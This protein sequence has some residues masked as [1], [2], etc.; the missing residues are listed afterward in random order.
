M[1]A[2]VGMGCRNTLCCNR[3]WELFELSL[4]GFHPSAS[5]LHVWWLGV[6]SVTVGSLFK[7][8]VLS[9]GFCDVYWLVLL[10]VL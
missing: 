9:S 5:L 2:K 8:L 4:S 10:C 3:N 1:P 6:S 7:M